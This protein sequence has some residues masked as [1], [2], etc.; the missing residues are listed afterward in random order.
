MP[1]SKTAFL[2]AAY[3]GRATARRDRV[4]DDPWARALAGDEGREMAARFDRAF[5]A[6]ELWIALRTR[7]LDDRVAQLTERGVAQVVLLGAGLD[8][9]AARLPRPA[10]EGDS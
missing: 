10:R 9:R 6:G 3:R 8:T 1:V 5:P 2:V 4:C 7:F